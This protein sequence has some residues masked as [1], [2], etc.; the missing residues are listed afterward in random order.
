MNKLIGIIACGGNSSRMGEDKSM[1]NYHGLP[2]RYHLYALL[3]P[4]CD[5]VL[6]SCNNSQLTEILPGYN[7]LLD[8]EMFLKIGPMAAL[9]TA[10]QKYPEASFLLIG[11]DYPNLQ[12]RDLEELVQQREENLDALCYYNLGRQHGEPLLAIYEHACFRELKKY[13]SN[14]QHSLKHFLGSLN[15]RYLL[16]AKC[17]SVASIDTPEQRVECIRELLKEKSLNET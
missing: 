7:Y 3:Q 14:A 12:A 9:L 15:T 6:L 8:D 1:I 16:P 13:H 5:E 17:K 10:H 4:F 2:Q 11:C